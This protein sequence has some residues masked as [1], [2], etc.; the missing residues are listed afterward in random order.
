MHSSERPEIAEAGLVD[1]YRRRA[2][3]YEAIYAK[4]E[5]QADLAFLEKEI[6]RRLRGARVL[7]VAC[8]TGYWTERVAR[9]AAKIV[10]TDA[11][12]EPMRIARAKSYPKDVVRFDLA[13][14][15][16]L[17]PRLGP[18]DAGLA[19]FWW[20]HVPRQRVAPFLDSLHRCLAAGARVIFMDNVYAQ[21]SSTPVSEVDSHG[22]TYQMRPLADGSQVRVLKNFPTK[23]ELREQLAPHAASFSFEAWQYY[24]LAEYTLKK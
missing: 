19:V 5:R 4:P 22:N 23:D 2:G 1:Y 17:D 16:A 7:E 10:A 24:W 13:D 11:A 21:G 18:F 14:A 6:P 20:S 12:D 9:S 8:G 15:Y 3:E